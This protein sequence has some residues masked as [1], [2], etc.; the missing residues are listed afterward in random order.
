MIATEFLD[1]PIS[2]LW[3]G[4]LS[5]RYKVTPIAIT[6][7]NHSASDS[8]Q[9]FFSFQHWRSSVLQCLQIPEQRCSFHDLAS[10]GWMVKIGIICACT[11]ERT[12]V[13]T[14][15]MLLL[16][17]SKSLFCLVSAWICYA[18]ALQHTWLDTRLW[19]DL[20]ASCVLIAVCIN[21]SRSATRALFPSQ[22]RLPQVSSS[23]TLAFQIS[24]SKSSI[25]TKNRLVAGITIW[26]KTTPGVLHL[27]LRQ[28]P[29]RIGAFLQRSFLRQST[30]GSS[31]VG[32]DLVA[33]CIF[34]RIWEVFSESK[35]FRQLFH[36]V[37]P[38]S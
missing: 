34:L 28:K 23:P 21:F 11:H 18:S 27:Y 7:S 32:V 29:G 6:A 26:K 31:F 16:Y 8:W 19:V 30:N 36:F 1:H 22:G 24:S 14:H 38:V 5:P 9:R 15:D 37:L 4:S 25:A 13:W 33:L 17:V 2:A 35:H 10:S 12:H 20:Q 3:V